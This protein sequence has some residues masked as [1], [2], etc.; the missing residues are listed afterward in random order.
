[1][2]RSMVMAAAALVAGFALPAAAQQIV[3]APTAATAPT[4]TC[5]TTVERPDTG[6]LI[7]IERNGAVATTEL[8]G[9]DTWS[10][11]TAC[12]TR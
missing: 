1:M 10:T 2:G 4:Q 8:A 11:T 7:T 9:G 5:V 12:A 6:K 3:V